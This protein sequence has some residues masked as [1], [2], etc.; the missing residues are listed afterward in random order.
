M[1]ST[2]ARSTPLLLLAL[3]IAA[4]QSS[5]R[6]EEDVSALLKK[7]TTAG[8]RERPALIRA[9]QKAGPKVAPILATQLA[10]TD[11]GTQTRAAQLFGELRLKDGVRPLIVALKAPQHTTRAAAAKSLG[12]LGSADAVPRLCEA[13]NDR[14]YVVRQEAAA[15]LGSLRDPRAVEPLK[16]VLASD[17]QD[18]SGG[19]ALTTLHDGRSSY[20]LAR[21]PSIWLS[22]CDALARIGEPALPTLRQ[23]LSAPQPQLRARAVSLLLR[24]NDGAA[25]RQIVQLLQTGSVK[26]TKDL[27][28]PLGKTQSPLVVPLLLQTLDSQ[29]AA[30]R[31][32]AAA[33]LGYAGQRAVVPVLTTRYRARKLGNGALAALAQL[34]DFSSEEVFIDALSSTDTAAKAVAVGG[35]GKVGTTLC[36]QGLSPLCSDENARLAM[37]ARQSLGAILTREAQGGNQGALPYATKAA[38]SPDRALR[39]AACQAIAKLGG[40]E[41]APVL[42]ALL[43]SKDAYARRSAAQALESMASRVRVPLS[44]FVEG[45]GHADRYVRDACYRGAYLS[46]RDLTVDEKT[47]ILPELLF[48]AESKSGTARRLAAFGLGEV[49]DE[50][51]VPALIQ[52][53]GD[54]DRTVGPAAVKALTLITNLEFG[55]NVARWKEWWSLKS[56]PALPAR[57]VPF[58][59]KEVSFAQTASLRLPFGSPQAV[60]TDG[61]YAYL[62]NGEGGL[63]VVDIRKPSSPTVVAQIPTGGNSQFSIVDQWWA[64][65]IFQKAYAVALSGTDLYLATHSDGYDVHDLYIYRIDVTDPR[66]PRIIDTQWTRAGIPVRLCAQGTRVVALAEGVVHLFDFKEPGRPAKP[67]DWVKQEKRKNIKSVGCALRGSQIFAVNEKGKLSVLPFDD[68]ARESAMLQVAGT[69]SDLCLLDGLVSVAAG[70]DLLI[71][72]TTAPRGDAVLGKTTLSDEEITAL[73]SSGKRIYAATK[74]GAL[75]AVEAKKPVDLRA[76]RLRDGFSGSCAAHKTVGCAVVPDYGLELFDLRN[77]QRQGARI[78]TAG[79]FRNFARLSATQFVCALGQGGLAFVAPDLASRPRFLLPEGVTNVNSVFAADNRLYLSSDQGMLILS[80]KGE[81]LGSFLPSKAIEGLKPRRGQD[82]ATLGKIVS[83]FVEQKTAYLLNA[84]AGLMIVDVSD[85]ASPRLLGRY[86]T[87]TNVHNH[88]RGDDLPEWLHTRNTPQNVLV[89]GNRAYVAMGRS[90]LYVID[91]S[92]PKAPKFVHG[93]F[94]R[95]VGKMSAWRVHLDDSR[96]YLSDLDNGIY[97][98]DVSDPGSLKLLDHYHTANAHGL[99]LSDSLI[100]VADGGY[101]LRAIQHGDRLAH[102]GAYHAPGIWF[103]QAAWDDNEILVGDRAGLRRFSTGER[104]RTLRTAFQLGKPITKPDG[105]PF[106]P[107]DVAA[108]YGTGIR[109]EADGLDV[110]SSKLQ[111]H[112]GYQ[113]RL[114]PVYQDLSDEAGFPRTKVQSQTVAIDPARGRIKFSD[115]DRD[116]IRRLG[117]L[118]LTMGIPHRVAIHEDLLFTI[119]EEGLNLRCYD[120][121]DPLKPQL[122]SAIATGGFSCHG[123]TVRWPYV[124]ASNNGSAF[125]VYDFSDPDN[126]VHTSFVGPCRAR[127]MEFDDGDRLYCVNWRT[128]IVDV[129]DIT[130]PKVVGEVPGCTASRFCA[131]GDFLYTPVKGELAIYNVKDPKTPRKV[132]AYPGYCAEP[133]FRDGTLYLA[134]GTF[135]IVD[136]RNPATPRKIASLPIQGRTVAVDRGFAYVA[137]D[138]TLHVVDISKPTS[139]RVASGLTGLP[140]KYGNPKGKANSIAVSK[141]G[142]HLFVGIMWHGFVVVD[143]RDKLKPRIVSGRHDTAGDYTGIVVDDS[144]AYIGMNWGALY[145]ADVSDPAKPTLIGDTRRIID[146]ATG[147]HLHGKTVYFS[148]FENRPTLR[149]VDAK[150][151]ADPKLLSEWRVPARWYDSRRGGGSFAHRMGKY[152]IIPWA[153][154]VLDVSEPTAPRLVGALPSRNPYHQKVIARDHYAYLASYKRKTSEMHVVSLHDPK[155]PKIVGTLNANFS[156]GYYFG[157]GVYLRGDYL[158]GVSFGPFVVLD[159]RDPTKPKIASITELRGFGSDCF[160]NYPYAYVTMYYGGLNVLDISDPTNPILI[161]WVGYGGYQDE[162]GWDNLGCYQSVATYRGSAFICE[163]YTGL[164]TFDIP[165]PCQAPTGEVTVRAQ[166]ASK[167]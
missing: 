5:A 143:V 154:G 27:C 122:R 84:P 107:D 135:D 43:A 139:P 126:P 15:A 13:L 51:S 49:G 132:A 112:A 148:G 93:F 88:V 56:A 113:N 102:A 118:H 89:A 161:D 39:H 108:L 92:D 150:N 137:K 77:P 145:I 65:K 57:A 127:G 22:T 121:S 105:K 144:R 14:F 129:K 24:L 36:L 115:G 159:V 151:P 82:A 70:P 46:V 21:F 130:R 163:Y 87:E 78:Q 138:S 97:V 128:L 9:L 6:G 55:A 30:L 123:L 156:G 155:D 8:R 20:T 119:N 29:D 75:Y 7:L 60:A 10:S 31:D 33:A 86:D 40:P 42:A 72:D 94:D 134:G 116:P 125:T 73:R 164:M 3:A 67:V 76:T 149:I 142:N 19:P 95:S 41:D 68:T 17:H 80:S 38:A 2:I 18:A 32:S 147:P 91:V 114:V 59:E 1:R 61:K 157:H 136:V 110:T 100:V 44:V 71:V 25:L 120:I 62:A 74:S 16:K 90:G 104:S 58:E 166:P 52:L 99:A 54:R 153:C 162:A 11:P 152:L 63:V 64:R 141:D 101:G 50:R 103:R 47:A 48:L 96:L 69:A 98:F 79:E 66:R 117:K 45:L 165:T 28:L 12:M 133:I 35:L 81:V 140:D 53:A 23:R 37:T 109:I 158:Y 160:I 131:R 146:G 124:G 167:R 83:T 26:L 4:D 106:G 111:G 34:A 85:P